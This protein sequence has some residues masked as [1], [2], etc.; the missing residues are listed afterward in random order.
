MNGRFKGGYITRHYGN[1]AAGVQA[2][3]LELAQINYM[4]EESFI[5]DAEK[6]ALVQALIADLLEATLA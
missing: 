5:Y 6:A 3:Q 2:V 1:P 4:N